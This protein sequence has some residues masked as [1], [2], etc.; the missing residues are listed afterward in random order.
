MSNF[1]YISGVQ[2]QRQRE[3]LMTSENPFDRAPFSLPVRSRE[4]SNKK[5]HLSGNNNIISF[6]LLYKPEKFRILSW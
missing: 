1:F 5:L 6:I 2:D 3:N 4:K